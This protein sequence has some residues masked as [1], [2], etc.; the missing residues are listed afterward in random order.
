MFKLGAFSDEISQDLDLACRVCGAFGVEGVEIRGVWDTP[1]QELTDAQVADIK[2]IVAGHGMVVCSLASPFGKCE[3][4]DAAEVAVH[5]DYLRRCSAIALELGCSLVRGFAF[6]GHGRRE[7]PWAQMLK[8]YEPVP[9]ILEEKGTLLG[10]ENEAA[11][12]VGTAGHT[13]HFLDRLG[14][15][16]VKAI[17]DPA[18]HVQDVEGL[19]TPAFPDG[20]NLLKN[21]MVHVHVK[22]AAP[23]PDGRVPNV[24][25]GQGIIGWDR[26][27]QAFKDDGYAGFCSLETHVGPESLTPELKAK[28]GHMMTGTGRE[29][30]SRICLAW[31]REAVDRLE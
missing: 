11:C 20:Y 4:E 29:N 9:G 10:L 24:F 3:L 15:P 2:R 16:R 27:L 12:Y 31:I 22:D 21:D 5:M 28:Y 30:A 1:S 25:M 17:W 26:Q 19:E 13:R 8:A 6:W 14:C 7:K 23:A 18:N